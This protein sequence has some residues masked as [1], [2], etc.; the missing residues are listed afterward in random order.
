MTLL[1]DYL[2]GAASYMKEK[3]ERL[4]KLEEQYKRIYD[5]DLKREMA[6]IRRDMTKKSSEIT[7]ELL[8]NLVEFRALSKYYPELLEVYLDDEYIGR[9]ISKK[10][11]LLDYKPLP[12]D[13]A[14][15]KLQQLQQWRA[16]LKDARGFM[17][18]WVGTIDAKALIATYPALRGAVQGSLYKDDALAAI[19]KADR[20]LLKEGWLLLIGDTLI[21]IPIAKFQARINQ[22]RYDESAAKAE[23]GRAMGKGT[24]AET[25]ALR[26]YQ[27]VSKKKQ[28][29]ERALTQLLLANPEYLK[30]LKKKKNWLSR[31]RQGNLD[32]LVASITPRTIKERVWLD[33]M[34]KKLDEK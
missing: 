3:K 27:E 7:T 34:R 23:L 25:V 13:Q 26:K 15:A 12:A 1:I 8:Y 16:Q 11:W 5:T 31:E 10:A 20:M 6:D 9:I 4:R 22:L 17:R 24:V 33:Q 30:K 29:Y 19:K 14:A 2:E 21:Q 18:R 28:H 32:R